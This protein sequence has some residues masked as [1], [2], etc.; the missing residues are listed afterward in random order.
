L[1]HP[2]PVHLLRELA[3]KLLKEVLSHQLVLKR[4]QHPLFD[5]LTRDRQL[6]GAG[7]AVAS[8]EASKVVA[9]I[10]DEPGTAFA[11]LR[12]TREQILRPPELVKRLPSWPAFQFR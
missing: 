5:F 7:A 6:V 9:R 8:A 1:L 4:A 11:A 2:E 3:A 12:E 10:D